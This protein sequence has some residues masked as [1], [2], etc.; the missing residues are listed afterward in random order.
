[1]IAVDTNILVY[2]HRE[3][4]PW[5][6]RACKELLKISHAPWCIPWPCV[7]EFVAI[8]THPKIYDPPS[9]IEIALKAVNGFRKSSH[10]RLLQEQQGYWEILKNTV[11]TSHVTGPRLHDAR[12]VAL[13]IQHAVDELWSADRDFTRFT[14]VRVVNPLA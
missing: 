10:L 2:A 13:C 4:N 8:V 6:D 12:I 1:M 11:Q 5:H 7:H 3:D 14:G 9:S